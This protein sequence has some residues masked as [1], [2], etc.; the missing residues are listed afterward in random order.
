MKEIN[1]SEIGIRGRKAILTTDTTGRII[2]LNKAAQKLLDVDKNELIGKNFIDIFGRELN[3]QERID[4]LKE[5]MINNESYHDFFKVKRF[6]NEDEF[7]WTDL[8]FDPLIIKDV[9]QGFTLML[10]EVPES[11]KPRE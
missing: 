5:K 10:S 9:K 2:T 3:P 6:K 7:I 11:D 4:T 1:F 8:V